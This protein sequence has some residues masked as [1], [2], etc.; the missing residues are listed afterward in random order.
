MIELALKDNLTGLANHNQLALSFHNSVQQS[1]E[2]HSGFA[3]LVLDLDSVKQIKDK[4]GE[5]SGDLVLT[6]FAVILSDCIGYKDQVF[7][8]A[9][10]EFTVLLNDSDNSSVH[11]IIE[12]IHQ[13]VTDNPIL[14][15][16]DVSCSIGSANYQ[17][18]DNP[19]SLFERAEQALYQSKE[20][21]ENELAVVEL[22]CL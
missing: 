19:A 2:Q 12:R 9:G 10:Y 7:R 14:S 21:A 17:Q 16:F 3:L 8:Y 20:K 18:G 13:A 11:Y 4:F 1:M 6:S 22:C 15:E 5:Q